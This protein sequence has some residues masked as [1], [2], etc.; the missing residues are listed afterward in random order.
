MDIMGLGSFHIISNKY[1][2]NWRLGSW[3]FL[4]CTNWIGVET[5]E[6]FEYHGIGCNHNK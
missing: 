2:W 5:F 3:Y 4:L 1:Y 6:V